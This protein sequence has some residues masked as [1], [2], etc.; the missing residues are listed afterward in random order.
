VKV[1]FSNQ[2]RLYFRE[3]EEVLFEKEYFSFE[4]S[5]IQYVRGLIFEIRDTL[6]VRQKKTAPVYFDRYGK[7]M[8]YSMFR[9]SKA[10]Q[11]YVFFNIYQEDG[12]AVYFVRYI[13]NNHMIAQLI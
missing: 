8:F 12:E 4:D 11:W 5:A 9:K 13:S 3:L 2:V 10:T 1:L 6:P 7:D